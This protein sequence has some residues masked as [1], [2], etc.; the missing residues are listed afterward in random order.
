MNNDSERIINELLTAVASGD[1]QRAAGLYA[2]DRTVRMAGVPRALGG[3]VEGRDRIVDDI[4]QRPP[5]TLDV[6]LIFGDNEHSCAVVKRT[7]T[8]TTTATFKG[9]NSQFTSYEC[10]LFRFEDGR[11]KEQTTYINWLDA[12][13]QTGL[14]DL[15]AVLGT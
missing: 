9:S 14:I 4:A 13:V 6:R 15:G 1:G 7:G 11:V 2:E 5:S 3:L 10:V 8:V 12:Y